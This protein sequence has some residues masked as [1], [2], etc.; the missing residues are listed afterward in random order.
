MIRVIPTHEQK[1][2]RAHQV[3]TSPATCLKIILDAFRD[4]GVTILRIEGEL[5]EGFFTVTSPNIRISKHEFDSIQQSKLVMLLE[6][7]NSVRHKLFVG[8]CMYL[9]TASVAYQRSMQ[10]WSSN[11]SV[12]HNS[13][14]EGLGI[15]VS[16]MFDKVKL[17]LR[18]PHLMYC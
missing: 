1:L 5:A 13:C 12:P 3:I 9:M 6:D 8:C 2:I 16:K 7:M 18:I 17:I 14:I 4:V 11:D 10:Y 15:A